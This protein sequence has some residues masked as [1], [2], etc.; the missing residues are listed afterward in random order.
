VNPG[1]ACYFGLARN[2]EPNLVSY[3]NTNQSLMGKDCNVTNGCGVH[4]HNGTSCFNFT[5]QGGHIYNKAIFPIDPWLRTMYHATDQYG[6][7]YFTGCVETGVPS[8]FDHPF[9]IHSN[10]GSRVSCG[11]LKGDASRFD[12]IDPITD[13]PIGPLWSVVN[14]TTLGTS[15]NLLNIEAK[16]LEPYKSARITFD[17]PKRIFCEKASPFAIF[18]DKR[19][20]F[21]GKVIP[22]GSHLVTAL[23]F[24][25]DN[26]SG[27]PGVKLS[28]TFEVVGCTIEYFARSIDEELKPI[29]NNT[30]VGYQFESNIEANI[31][32]GFTIE[33]VRFIL[34]S[35]TSGKTVRRQLEMEAPYSSRI[36]STRISLAQGAYSISTVINGIDHGKLFLNAVPE[37]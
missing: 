21:L 32:C 10:S 28:K 19:G 12:L 34:K 16:F 23:P 37:T 9:I 1:I 14:Y 20:N 6:D 13:L 31:I 29:R 3:L 36:F 26:C 5:T 7:A 4:I 27:Q 35:E 18:G 25:G 33:E 24:S 2:L 8:F 17:N 11:L 15:S 30:F 22:L